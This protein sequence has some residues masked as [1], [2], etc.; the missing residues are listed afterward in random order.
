[1][2]EIRVRSPST[3]KTSTVGSLGGDAED[4]GAP[5]INTKIIDGGPLGGPTPIHGPKVCCELHRQQR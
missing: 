5:T 4:P 2:P 1:M 3:R